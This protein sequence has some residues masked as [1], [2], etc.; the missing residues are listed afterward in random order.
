MKKLLNP[1]FLIIILLLVIVLFQRECSRPV[2]EIPKTD[3][4]TKDSIVVQVDTVDRWHKVAAQEPD[5]VVYYSTDTIHD[6]AAN[7]LNI[8]KRK[9]WDDDKA[10]ITCTDSVYRNKLLGAH[11][12]AK[13]F[14]HD[15]THYITEII[16]QP[17]P[18]P[19]NKVLIGFETGWIPDKV[20]LAPTIALMT[21]RD[22]LYSLSYDPLNKL[23]TVS[24]MW[25]IRLSR[26][27]P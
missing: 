10:L 18:A 22:H 19:R 26:R 5:S 1:A 3:T 6:S 23:A 9:L 27:P 14:I 2:A 4:I 11:V 13:F 21:K 12:D 16:R 24:C 20:I 15:T 8:Y 7:I 25:K 17:A